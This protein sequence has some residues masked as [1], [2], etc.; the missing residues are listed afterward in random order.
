MSIQNVTMYPDITPNPL[1]SLLIMSTKQQIKNCYANFL[2]FFGF[3]IPVGPSG[4]LS[5]PQYQS[6]NVNICP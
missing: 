2:L 1:N 4:S 6:Q 3:L 5:V